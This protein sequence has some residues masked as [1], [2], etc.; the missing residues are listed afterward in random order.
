MPAL[1][2]ACVAARQLPLPFPLLVRAGCGCRPD[3]VVT[4]MCGSEQARHVERVRW[5]GPI[6]GI[7]FFYYCDACWRKPGPYGDTPEERDARSAAA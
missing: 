2:L 3:T 7:S 5:S 4:C 1:V 6:K